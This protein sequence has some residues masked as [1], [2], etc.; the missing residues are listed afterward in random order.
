M[1]LMIRPESAL[2]SHPGPVPDGHGP[3]SENKIGSR[4]DAHASVQL[5][6]GSQHPRGLPPS[7]TQYWVGLH[8]PHGLGSDASTVLL[9]SDGPPPSRDPASTSTGPPPSTVGSRRQAS[10]APQ[11]DAPA[12]HRRAESDSESQTLVHC[13]EAAPHW[14]TK[15]AH[16]SSHV[17]PLMASGSDEHATRATKANQEI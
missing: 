9:A 14:V 2:A 10:S 4:H 7:T 8:V 15:F 13:G 16:T 11:L 6:G 12:A 5:A 1:Q 17:G 3:A